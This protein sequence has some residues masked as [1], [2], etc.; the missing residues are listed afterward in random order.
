MSQNRRTPLPNLTGTVTIVTGATSGIGL[1]M[2]VSGRQVS[3][4]CDL[5]WLSPSGNS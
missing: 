4:R 1:R 5:P 3:R 2:T